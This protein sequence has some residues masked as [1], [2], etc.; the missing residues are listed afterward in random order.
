MRRILTASL[1]SLA[2]LSLG[3]CVLAVGNGDDSGSDTDYSWHD[4]SSASSLATAV[5]VKLQDD[6]LTH[7][8]DLQVSAD[9]SGRVYI[10][11]MTSNPEVVS[12]ALQLALDTPDVKSVR[13]KIIVIK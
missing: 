9:S 3:G 5:R 2:L 13:C 4:S 7:G 1:L 10:R 6:A 11:G 8:T 12:R